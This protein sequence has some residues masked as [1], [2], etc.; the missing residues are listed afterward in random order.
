MNVILLLPLSKVIYSFFQTLRKM[1]VAEFQG[2]DTASS[3]LFIPSRKIHPGVGNYKL[4]IQVTIED[5]N[6]NVWGTRWRSG[7]TTRL[8]CE[9]SRVQISLEPFLSTL[10]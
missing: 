9:S 10:Q 2:N 5:S 3:L 8:P 6:Y 4:L 7:Q 1:K